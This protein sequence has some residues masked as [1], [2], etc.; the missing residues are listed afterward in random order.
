MFS[1]TPHLQQY[2]SKILILFY[3]SFRESEKVVKSSRKC[4]ELMFPNLII[5]LIPLL[6]SGTNDGRSFINTLKSIVL[7]YV[8]L[9]KPNICVS[10][11]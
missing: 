11:N 10:V 3:S 1:S 2:F 7:N 6:V 5:S 8:T 4:N 9:F